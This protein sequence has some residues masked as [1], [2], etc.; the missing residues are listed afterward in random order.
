MYS[1]VWFFCLVLLFGSALDRLVFED[2]TKEEK[3]AIYKDVA[4]TLERMGIKDV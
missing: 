1:L 4:K 2:L 3:E